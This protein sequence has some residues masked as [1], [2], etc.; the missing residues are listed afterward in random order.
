MSE[1]FV[2]PEEN[3]SKI[4]DIRS[5]TGLTRAAF[6]EKYGIP[7][8][9]VRDWE[10]GK[11]KCPDY[12]NTLLERCVTNDEGETVTPEVMTERQCRF[13]DTHGTSPRSNFKINST[14]GRQEINA[15]RVLPNL[16]GRFENKIELIAITDKAGRLVAMQFCG[17]GSFNKMINKNW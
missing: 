9:T 1:E 16:I 17:A 15:G 4:R 3:T 5:L 8:N 12:V 7:I 14:S 6:A 13:L 2:S 10:Q 11:R